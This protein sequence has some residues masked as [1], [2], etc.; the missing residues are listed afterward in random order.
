[1]NEAFLLHAI[2]QTKRVSMWPAIWHRLRLP[3]LVT[4]CVG[5]GHLMSSSPGGHIEEEASVH[6]MQL[7]AVS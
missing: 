2:G 7:Q 3:E 1:M 5:P 4:L 6:S